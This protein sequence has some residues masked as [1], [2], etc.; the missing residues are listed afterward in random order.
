[1]IT[2]ARGQLGRELTRTIPRGY[3]LHA[4]SHQDLDIGDRDAVTEWIKTYRPELVV[5]AAGYTAVDR[6]ES[7]RDTAFRVNCFAPGY[8][9]ESLAQ[10]GGRL[11]HVST[12]YVF[13]GNQGRP[14]K[15]DDPPRPLSVY[16]E[17]KLGGERRILE[18]LGRDALVMRTSWLYSAS[19]KNFVRT[20]LRLMREHEEIRVVSDQIG[21]PTWARGLAQAIWAAAKR[22]ELSGVCHWTDAGVASWYDF[23]VATQEEAV[24]RRLLA[25]AITIVPIRTED[26]PVAAMR[27]PYSVLDKHD[28]WKSLGYVSLHWHI[29]LRKLVHELSGQCG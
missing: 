22:P 19:G 5:N 10:F 24:A 18:I 20:M 21:T 26:Y 28:T 9:A 29:A 4:A 27:P 17:S 13:D 12:D 25:R 14:Y 2:G 3:Q 23:A 16:G 6:A 8:L 11:I 15:P 7:D 1:M